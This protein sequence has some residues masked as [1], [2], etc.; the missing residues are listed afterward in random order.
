MWRLQGGNWSTY[1]SGFYKTPLV[2]YGFLTLLAGVVHLALGAYVYDK[3]TGS[4]N[5]STAYI[6]TPKQH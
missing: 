4:N 2:F 1:N 5:T 6:H 3:V